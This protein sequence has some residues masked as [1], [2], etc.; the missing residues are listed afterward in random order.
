MD[1]EKFL[2]FFSDY[3]VA[4]VITAIFLTVVIRTVNLAFQYIEKRMGIRS[5]DKNIDIRNE[6]NKKVQQLINDFLMKMGGKR[7]QVIEFSNSVTSVAFLPFRYMTCTYETYSYE[8]SPASH[9][10]D[11]LPT[12]LFTQLFDE[13]Q[14]EK[15]KE[16]NVNS[17]TLATNEIIY[18]LLSKFGGDKFLIT[19]MRS[20]K[21]KPVGIIIFEKQDEFSDAD[22]EGLLYLSKQLTSLLC[23]LDR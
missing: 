22:K 11:K 17:K 2:Q 14:S 6:V 10:V 3:G 16:Y 7:V 23:I 5:H 21:G 15:F 18:D 9:F 1:I 8:S 19:L 20:I 12:S 13:L 4:F